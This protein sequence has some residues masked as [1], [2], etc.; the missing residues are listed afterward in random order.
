MFRS[1]TS[2]NVARRTAL[3]VNPRIQSVTS[4]RK[5]LLSGAAPP[6]R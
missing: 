1:R 4:E 2:R 3:R 5:L 6:Y